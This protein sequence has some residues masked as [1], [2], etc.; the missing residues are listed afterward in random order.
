MLRNLLGHF[1][2]AGGRWLPVQQYTAGKM[3]QLRTR[4]STWARPTTTSSPPPSCRC[5]DDDQDGG[6]VQVQPLAAG[7][8][9]G[10]H[11]FRRKGISFT[12]CAA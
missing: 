1:E 10:L 4:P 5:G 7:L 11:D 6:L 12:A 2:R 8:E 3:E 9:P